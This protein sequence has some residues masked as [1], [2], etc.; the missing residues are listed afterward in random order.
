MSPTHWSRSV[1]ARMIAPSAMRTS[2]NIATV[3]LSA[4][5]A[6][7]VSS[8]GAGVDA[9]KALGV[10]E[11]R[12]VLR[13]HSEERG[14]IEITGRDLS[15]VVVFLKPVRDEGNSAVT[16]AA[17]AVIRQKGAKFRPNL[18]IVARGDTVRFPN[19]DRI[20]HN[21]FSYSPAQAFDLGLYR[22]G[23]SK[24][25]TFTNAGPVRIFCSIHA[26]MHAVVYV[27]PTRYHALTNERGEFRIGD[28]PVGRYALQTWH[29]NL[30]D[31]VE[32]VEVRE[33]DVQ[34]GAPVRTEVDLSGLAGAA[35]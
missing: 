26:D 2:R 3:L 35:P 9:E 21:V 34:A 6:T 32:S 8:I 20:V 16:A 17:E 11:G 22:K 29:R 25:V 33:I 15:G 18:L 28:V 31:G 5:A 10:V 19:D 23:D 14:T 30:P 13:H 1:I 27:A 4:F 12:V 7:V 24:S